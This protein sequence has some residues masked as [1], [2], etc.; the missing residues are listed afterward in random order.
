MF[1]IQEDT[2]LNTT[3]CDRNFSCKDSSPCCKVESCVGNSIIFV[4]K[5]ERRCNYYQGFGY[6]N[7]CKCPV[8]I[9]IYKK[10]KL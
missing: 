3:R 9:E 1:I 8:R 7:V 6:G 5:L 10:Y 2:V 4:S